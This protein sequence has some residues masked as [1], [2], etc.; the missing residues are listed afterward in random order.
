[1]LALDSEPRLLSP[2]L[3]DEYRSTA[4]AN[5]NCR[6][7]QIRWQMAR[8]FRAL[9]SVLT[10]PLLWYIPQLATTAPKAARHASEAGKQAAV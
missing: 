4:H 1:M 5:K 7:F 8:A 9:A 6:A 3:D 2:K 10:G